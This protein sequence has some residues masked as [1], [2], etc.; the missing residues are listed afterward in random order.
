MPKPVSGR[1]FNNVLQENLVL[2]YLALKLDRAFVFEDYVWSHSPLPWTIHDFA[3]RPSRM[4]MNAFISGPSAGGPMSAPRAVSA[5]FWHSV[6][7]RSKTKVISSADQPD[8]VEG[9]VLLDWWIARLE[10]LADMCIEIDSEKKTIFDFMLFGD[11]RVL[12]LWPGLSKSPIYADFEWSSLVQSAVNANLPVIHPAAVKAGAPHSTLPGLVAVHLR[13]GDFKGHCKYLIRWNAQY[14]GFNRFPEMLDKFDTS[15]DRP[16]ELLRQY[17]MQHCMPEVDQIVE[18][19]R[20]VRMANPG[21]NR[22]YALTNGKA[23]WI[24]ELK[25]ALSNDGWV[26]VKSSLDLRLDCAQRHV[27]MAVDMAIAEKAEVFVGNG[28]S[29]LTSNVLTLRLAKGSRM[30]A[31]RLL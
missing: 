11:T 1:G 27:S 12:S 4:P 8:N 15:R 19:L 22:V 3:L 5:E 17:Y 28:F 26:D 7:P 10:S 14:M 2:S 16:A 31:N 29:S 18:R 9:V 13:R 20:T 30:S 21:L 24:S 25:S 6:C 23:S